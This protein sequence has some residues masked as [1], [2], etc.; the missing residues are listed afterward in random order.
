MSVADWIEIEGEPYERGRQYGARVSGAVRQNIEAYLRLVEFHAGLSRDAAL[1]EAMAFGPIVEAHAPDLL[2]EMRG[3]ADGA[4]CDLVEVLLLNARSELMG[5]LD[6]ASTG[7]CT[8]LAA[9]PE[10]AE[11][12]KV[13]LAQN[14]DWYTAVEPQPVLLRVRQPGRPDILT[15]AEA[16]Q[17]AKIGLNAAGLGVGL[18]FLAHA[19][20]GQGLP[21]HVI[22]RQMLGCAHLGEALH[23]ALSV[24]R[25]GAANLPVAHAEGEILDLELTATDAD[26][27]YADAGWLVHANHYE[28]L[29]LRSGDTGLPTSMS[30][31][32]RAARARRLLSTAVARGRVSV[33]TFRSILRDHAYGAYAICRHADP[34][35]PPLH[36]SATRASVIMDLSTRS[37]YLAVG[38]PCREEYRSFR[39]VD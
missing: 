36:Q 8:A 34:S 6:R 39:L 4:G 38:Q 7:E 1:A 26:F 25:G 13:L 9:A 24:P 27:L 22:L 29:R 5:N 14:W 20:R 15:L 28:S 12:G 10:V 32:A 17:V 16:G 3:I 21:V 30:T 11:Q 23:A 31:L 33:E 37:F 2:L 19:H 18:N 35:E